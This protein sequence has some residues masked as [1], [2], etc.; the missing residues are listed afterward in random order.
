M[1]F[2]AF[3]KILTLLSLVLLL[4]ACA[5]DDGDESRVVISAGDTIIPLN[6]LQYQLP[7]VVQ[8]ADLDG[9][10]ANNITVSLKVKVINYSKGSYAHTDLDGDGT[11]DEWVRSESVQC[12]AED[13]NNNNKLDAGEDINGNGIL[14]PKT[15][16]VTA[17][18]SETPTLIPGT[19]QL[20]TDGNGFGYFSLTYPKSQGSWV[21]VQITATAEDG[22]AENRAIDEQRL[23][24]ALS[25]LKP[26]DDPPA[27]VVS[28]YGTSGNC[29]DTL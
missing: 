28:P 19:S 4:G 21:T 15:P 24:V 11:T 22:F 5:S 3:Q 27:F 10:P 9:G 14:E 1:G 7:F 20:V 25:D 26:V 8:V 17:L 29:T 16:S 13:T 2:K 23:F 18:S 6:D 12:N